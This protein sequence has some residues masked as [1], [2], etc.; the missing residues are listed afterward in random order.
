MDERQRRY[1]EAQ[2]ATAEQ[3]DRPTD[4]DGDV[5]SQPVDR[6]LGALA[7]FATY[8]G[9]KVAPAW[10]DILRPEPGNV[11]KTVVQ[12]M[13]GAAMPFNRIPKGALGANAFR[14]AEDADGVASPFISTAERPRQ[15]M[16]PTLE[17]Y[18]DTLKKRQKE[19]YGPGKSLLNY[20]R[21]LTD[22]G[23]VVVPEAVR[24]GPVYGARPPV[25]DLGPEAKRLTN[26]HVM[27]NYDDLAMQ[28]LMR[29]PGGAPVNPWYWPTARLDLMRRVFGDDAAEHML[30]RIHGNVAVTS[31]GTSV[32]RNAEEGLLTWSHANAGRPMN[33]LE[34]KDLLGK[35]YN[36]KRDAAA[37]INETGA[38]PGE[39]AFKVGNYK[40][41]LDG[42]GT[43]GAGWQLQN[44]RNL[45]PGV[46]VL[47]RV[48][49][50][51]GGLI[52]RNT[53][54]AKERFSTPAQ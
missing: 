40:L 36:W 25:R 35:A 46:T 19:D 14:A 9:G 53:G 18:V 16:P 41:G 54:E 10:P 15:K 48:M 2:A 32:M 20:D 17:E 13:L 7:P 8:S 42:A 34:R 44:E 52:N 23:D 31:P 11:G 4:W 27:R 21:Y 26:Q 51:E 45:I 1:R 22:P 38:I 33:E 50:R 30:S 28:G 43:G 39:G 24:V 29:D 12:N 49:A 47:D 37:A 6:P 5:V 3:W